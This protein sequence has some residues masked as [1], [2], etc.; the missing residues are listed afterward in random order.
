MNLSTTDGYKADSLKTSMSIF[1]IW[2]WWL[3]EM[4]VSGDNWKQDLNDK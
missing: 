2:K 3:Y 4:W 1:E